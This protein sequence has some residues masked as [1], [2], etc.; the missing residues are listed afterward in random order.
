[1][2]KK[3][4]S[5][6]I[7][8]ISWLYKHTHELQKINNNIFRIINSEK[9]NDEFIIEIQVIN[10]STIFKCSAKEIATQDQLLE[11]FS[12][13]DVRII[14][15]LATKEL[16]QPKNKII[17]FEYD[18]QTKKT[19]LKIKSNGSNEL[20]KILADQISTDSQLLK[21]LSQEDAHKTGYLLAIE[22]MILEKNAIEKSRQHQ[23][24]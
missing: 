1:M 18:E 16:L 5:A 10:K 13:S 17:G 14:T 3:K 4:F 8:Y 22:Q 15:Y 21:E 2:L 24:V 23:C 20:T 19:L 11:C 9:I 12:K 6:L 7:E